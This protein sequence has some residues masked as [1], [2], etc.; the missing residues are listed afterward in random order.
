MLT[1]ASP[2]AAAAILWRDSARAPD[3][4]E[5]MRI[6]AEDLTEIGLVDGIV[7]EPVGGAHRNYAAVA[8][9]VAGAIIDALKELEALGPDELLDARYA[10]YRDIGFYGE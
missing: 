9:A 5:N 4:A 2:E 10:K 6:T 1:V 3:A 8:E 7:P